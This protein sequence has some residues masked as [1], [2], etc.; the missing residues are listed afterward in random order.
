M[1]ICPMRV[2]LVRASSTPNNNEF[3]TQSK[4]MN[5]R[6]KHFEQVRTMNLR[7]VKDDIKHIAD[8][9]MEYAKTTLGKIFPIKFSVNEEALKNMPIKV[10]WTPEDVEIV[11]VDNDVDDISK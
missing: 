1:S 10:E 7:R 4:K 2:F 6:R 5:E 3:S 11:H 8:R 9:E